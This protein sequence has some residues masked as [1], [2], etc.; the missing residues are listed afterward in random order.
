MSDCVRTMQWSLPLIL[1][2]L[3]GELSGIASLAS[4]TADL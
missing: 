2:Y 4:P 1:T 3:D